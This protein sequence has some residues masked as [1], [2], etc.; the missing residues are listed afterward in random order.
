MSKHRSTRGRK[1]ATDAARKSRVI[2]TRVPQDLEDTL[3]DAAEKKRMTVS[4]LIRYVLEDTFNLVD[5]IVS[6]S[7]ALV[8]NVARDAKK[9]A[10]TARGDIPSDGAINPSALDDVDAWQD[11]IVNKPSACAQCQTELKRGKK[12]FRGLSNQENKQAIW[13]CSACIEKL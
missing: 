4:H 9:L 2:Q 10:A 11:V 12:A 6:D 7:S 8:E 3:K 13:L 5:G 1:P